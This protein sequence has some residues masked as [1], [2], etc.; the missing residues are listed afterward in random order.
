MG[1][2]ARNNAEWCDI[3]CRTHAT[4]TSLDRDVWVSLWRSPPWY[5]D[6]VT[7][8]DPLLVARV[9]DR[10]DD[11]AGCSVKD[12][13]ASLDLSGAGFRVLFEAAWIW[14]DPQP[15]AAAGWKAVR[16]PDELRAWAGAHSGGDVFRPALLDHPDVAVLLAC[17]AD[18][19]PAAGVIA[20]RSASVVGFS[21]LFSTSGDTDEVWRGAPAAVSAAFPGLPLVGYESGDSLAAARRAGFVSLG[22]LR[23]WLK[24]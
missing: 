17:G 10:I 15:P 1:L 20:N 4:P 23:V 7:L 14:R 12:S 5:P 19:S 9:L 18:G 21:N 8:A 3:V 16:T 6:A 2:A 11:T 13:F 24:D 22:P